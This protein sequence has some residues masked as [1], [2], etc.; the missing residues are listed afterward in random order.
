MSSLFSHCVYSENVVRI[1]L[2]HNI[3]DQN[4]VQL[5]SMKLGDDTDGTYIAYT[6][7]VHH[8]LA[9]CGKW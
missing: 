7:A 6:Q 1:I 5:M 8:A 2:L 3:C 9:A 4:A